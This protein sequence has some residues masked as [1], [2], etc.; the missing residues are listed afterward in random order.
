MVSSPP[1]SRE[2]TPKDRDKDREKEK[3]G[4]TPRRDRDSSSGGG[5]VPA[6]AGL[7]LNGLMGN[8]HGPRSLTPVSRH[9]GPT[10]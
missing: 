1:V 7:A 5:L 4:S 3:E 10:M 6:P 2:P 9:S 8:G